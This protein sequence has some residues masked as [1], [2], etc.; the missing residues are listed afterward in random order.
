MGPEAEHHKRPHQV[1]RTS[2]LPW[3]YFLHCN[4]LLLST[5]NTRNKTKTQK[6]EIYIKEL[7][8]PKRKKLF[9]SLVFYNL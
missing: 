9:L 8:T 5:K 6:I 1:L 7:Q 2:T 3:I 4:L